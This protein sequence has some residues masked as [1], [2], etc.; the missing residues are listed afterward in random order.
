[1]PSSRSS[2]PRQ[3]TPVN[4]GTP[5]RDKDPFGAAVGEIAS[6][7]ETKGERR[8]RLRLVTASRMAFVVA[9]TRV[10]DIP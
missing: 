8:G 4:I 3:A 5:K 1:M 6:L 7:V 9:D 2:R 10:A